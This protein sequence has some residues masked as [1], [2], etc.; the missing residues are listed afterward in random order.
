MIMGMTSL[1]DL[2]PPYRLRLRAGD[3]ELTVISDD[4][5][6]GLVDLALAGIHAPDA[7]PFSTPW[8]LR[9]S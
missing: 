1:A 5:V 8:T 3:L 7:M 6:P 4:D 9:R 2:W